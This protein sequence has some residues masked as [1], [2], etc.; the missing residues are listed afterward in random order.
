MEEAINSTDSS[1]KGKP[2]ARWGHKAHG[3]PGRV[4]DGRAA[5]EKKEEK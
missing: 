3:S 2:I 5:G 4:G 1:E